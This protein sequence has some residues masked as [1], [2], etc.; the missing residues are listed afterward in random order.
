MTTIEVKLK[1]SD[2]VLAYLERES[3]NRQIALDTVVSDVLEDYFH[4]PTNAD[5]VTGLRQSLLDVLGGNVRPADDVLAE[6]KQAFNFDADE[7]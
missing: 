1:I 4:E 3:Q 6:L 2:K 5:L 7:S